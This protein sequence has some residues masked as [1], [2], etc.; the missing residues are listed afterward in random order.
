MDTQEHQW[1]KIDEDQEA[2]RDE[3]FEIASPEAKKRRRLRI[4]DKVTIVFEDEPG[5]ARAYAR[6]VLEKNRAVRSRRAAHAP[7]GFINLPLLTLNAGT[8]QC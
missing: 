7:R 3:S 6:A 5:H 4:A 2:D 8:S 1:M